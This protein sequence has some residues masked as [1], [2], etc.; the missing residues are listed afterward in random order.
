MTEEPTRC[1]V[2]S[3]TTQTREQAQNISEA[4]VERRLAACVQILGPITST[5][6]W[7][8]KVETAQEWLLLV[9]T[10][11][12]LFDKLAEAVKD[13]HTYEVPELVAV[14]IA[15]GSSEYLAWLIEE[16]KDPAGG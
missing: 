4:L 13:M 7:K 10:R 16:T 8:G 2:V 3:T 6:R 1:I 15:K 12:E 14:E 9:K 11:E 5:Y